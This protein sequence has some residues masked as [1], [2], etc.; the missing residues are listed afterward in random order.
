MDIIQQLELLAEKLDDLCD[1]IVIVG[2]CTPALILDTNTAPDLRPTNDVDFI[3]KAS[4]YG[5][6]NN[7]IERLKEKGFSEREG[8]PIGRYAC[9]NLVIDVIPTE[10]N[11]LG[12]TNKWYKIAFDNAN[13]SEIA[14]WKI[15]QNSNS[16]LFCCYK[17]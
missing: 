7:F 5:K 16:N 9:D 13:L 15:Y 4:N 1:E 6:Y 17:I 11:V 2:G 3:I 14:K 12:F 8:D 10:V